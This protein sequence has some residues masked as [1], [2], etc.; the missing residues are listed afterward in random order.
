MFSNFYE[1]WARA[2]VFSSL[3]T[4]PTISSKHARTNKTL[5]FFHSAHRSLS[6]TSSNL[7]GNEG[8]V[9]SLW[10]FLSSVKSILA[11]THKHTHC[12][13]NVKFVQTRWQLCAKFE[14]CSVSCTCHDFV[15]SVWKDSLGSSR[16][17]VCAFVSVCVCEREREIEREIKRERES[18]WEK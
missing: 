7:W 15:W 13:R 5:I 12:E 4:F 9:L 18:S 3:P 14:L 1:K 8:A 17:A 2:S 6:I 16:Y 10:F 11:C